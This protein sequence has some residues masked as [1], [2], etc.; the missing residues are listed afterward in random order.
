[1]ASE[2]MA[3][4]SHTP[5]PSPQLPC[6]LCLCLSP[7]G[8]PRLCLSPLRSLCLPTRA[9]LCLHISYRWDGRS[10]NTAKQLWWTLY[11]SNEDL[12]FEWTTGS[13]WRTPRPKRKE[14]QSTHQFNS[15]ALG[16]WSSGACVVQM[17]APLHM[18]G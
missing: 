12:M 1:M 8:S 11:L 13:S 17:T 14:G 18:L 16:N 7:P 2:A 4:V 3:E 15:Y 6:S 9:R 10:Q 5:S